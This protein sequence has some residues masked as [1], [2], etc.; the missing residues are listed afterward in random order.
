MLG[1]LLA[2]GDSI[3]YGAWDPAGGWVARLR[4]NACAKHRTDPWLV[5]NL[6]IPGDTSA[7]LLRR[8]GEVE[9]IWATVSP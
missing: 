8:L 5:H 4:A 6:G 3:T 2:L 1:N 7:D 9:R